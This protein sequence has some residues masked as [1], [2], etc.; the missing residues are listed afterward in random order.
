ML[1]FIFKDSKLLPH[2]L[3]EIARYYII[4]YILEVRALFLYKKTNQVKTLELG[5]ALHQASACDLKNAV[6]LSCDFVLGD[7]GSY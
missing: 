1:L 5:N 2:Y 4:I 7:V 6:S 3:H